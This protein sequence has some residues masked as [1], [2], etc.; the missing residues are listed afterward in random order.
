MELEYI[1]RAIEALIVIGLIY[2]T[3]ASLK[4]NKT[5][6]S[7][8]DHAIIWF[9]SLIFI[10]LFELFMLGT[11]QAGYSLLDAFNGNMPKRIAEELF[12]K[13]I[14]GVGLIFFCFIFVIAG[15]P[16]NKKALKDVKE[17]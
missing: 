5:Q 17:N 12:F 9:A 16:T 15:L 8:Q 6:R 10:L 4:N 1:V 3:R 7:T 2:D 11:H 13:S 14:M